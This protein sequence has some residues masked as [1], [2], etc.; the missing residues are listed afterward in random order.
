MKKLY[1]S[2]RTHLDLSELARKTYDESG[3]Y[4]IYEFEK[5]IDDD[6]EGCV[7]HYEYEYEIYMRREKC[8]DGRFTAEE[9]NEWLED[10]Q[11]EEE[12]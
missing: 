4:N 5:M 6:D 2:T 11:K 7:W 9:V 3:D 8:H 10:W 1:G 12:C